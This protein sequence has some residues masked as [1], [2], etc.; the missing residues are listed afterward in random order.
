MTVFNSFCI[1]N[2]VH[3]RPQRNTGKVCDGNIRIHV[4]VTCILLRV[5]YIPFIINMYVTSVSV[6]AC[7]NINCTALPVHATGCTDNAGALS[8]PCVLC[9]THFLD[10]MLFGVFG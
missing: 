7:T 10:F 8:I 6:K 5:Y 3:V 2:Y 4:T 9:D 1:F